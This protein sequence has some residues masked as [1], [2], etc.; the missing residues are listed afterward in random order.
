MT[1]LLSDPSGNALSLVYNTGGQFPREM[2]TQ[3]FDTNQFLK[4]DL[5]L[6]YGLINWVTKGLFLGDYHVYATAQVDDVFI[7]DAE[8]VPGTRLHQQ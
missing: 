4:H 8:W 2:L 1:P 7:N 6:A 3:T 5:I